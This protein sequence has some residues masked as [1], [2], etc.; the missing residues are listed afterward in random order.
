MGPPKREV[1]LLSKNMTKEADLPILF[2]KSEFVRINF[3]D[4]RGRIVGGT[5]PFVCYVNT[6]TPQIN[7]PAVTS[8][9]LEQLDQRRSQAFE[10]AQRWDKSV[11]AISPIGQAQCVLLPDGD[12]KG[13]NFIPV[14]TTSKFDAVPAVTAMPQVGQL[15]VAINDKPTTV[16][17]FLITF[18]HMVNEAIWDTSLKIGQG[19]VGFA[20][21]CKGLDAVI[22]SGF[23]TK[24]KPEADL[25]KQKINNPDTAIRIYGSGVNAAVPTIMGTVTRF[26]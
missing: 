20:Q 21:Y 24:L 5:N 10:W 15:E 2:D 3:A 8:S 12:P 25:I 18:C 7:L 26:K 19:V 1:F 17:G 11:V 4:K 23:V 16:D 6:P 22:E 13:K 9:L 14:Q